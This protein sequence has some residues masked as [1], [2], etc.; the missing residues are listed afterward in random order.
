MAEF[1]LHS[2]L[3]SCL[4]FLEESGV[5]NPRLKKESRQ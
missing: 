1:R 3:A 4:L 5:E 2:L